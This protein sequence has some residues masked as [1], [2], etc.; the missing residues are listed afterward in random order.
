MYR[1]P[2]GQGVQ[3]MLPDV[4][5]APRELSFQLFCWSV[6]AIPLSSAH[7]CRYAHAPATSGSS[8]AFA[9]S[10]VWDLPIHSCCGHG[11][12]CLPSFSLDLNFQCQSFN[13]SRIIMKSSDSPSA[14]P[15]ALQNCVS[16]VCFKHVHSDAVSWSDRVGNLV[17]WI[18]KV[19]SRPHAGSQEKCVSHL[20]H[21]QR[22]DPQVTVS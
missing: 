3:M 21:H 8:L 14:L 20:G 19:T 7:L 1:L 9:F 5:L 2:C 16:G 17:V 22:C 6:A 4:A 15:F 12:F 11:F 18:G 10:V 13:D